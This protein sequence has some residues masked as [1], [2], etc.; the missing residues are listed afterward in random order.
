[1]R[2]EPG[3]VF[4]SVTTVD[5]VPEGCWTMDK[6]QGNQTLYQILSRRFS[7]MAWSDEELNKIGNAE[8]LQIAPQRRDGTLRKPVTI[9]IVRVSDDLYVRSYNGRGGS[10]FRAALRSQ[11][12]RI[13]AGGVE[14]DVTFVPENDSALNDQIDAAYRDK[15]GRYPQYVAPMLTAEVRS[16]TFKLVPDSTN[17]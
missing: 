4:D 5:G 1:V 3:R 17:A 8:E 7:M 10:W 9:W 16:T 11:E 13:R 12:G 15:Y 6:Q 14:K 2:I